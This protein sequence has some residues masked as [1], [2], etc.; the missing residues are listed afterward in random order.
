MRVRLEHATAALA[1]PDMRQLPYWEQQWVRISRLLLGVVA[2]RRRGGM[3][4]HRRALTSAGSS[5]RDALSMYG[6]P[7]VNAGACD[8]QCDRS[9][10]E[11]GAEAASVN[12]QSDTS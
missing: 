8:A 3:R 12:P 10:V 5:L 4:R 7:L 11:D 2:P 6:I 9:G 1:L